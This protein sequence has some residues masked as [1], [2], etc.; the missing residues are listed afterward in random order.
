MV[1]T[2]ASRWVDK[3]IELFTK[4]PDQ[5]AQYFKDVPGSK[6]AAAQLPQVSGQSPQSNTMHS[7]S[8]DGLIRNATALN[9][10]G[11]HTAFSTYP[12]NFGIILNG[13]QDG[14]GGIHSAAGPAGADQQTHYKTSVHCSQLGLF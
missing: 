5:L 2:T 12:E 4:Y 1:A 13:L 6:H 14:Q 11:F 10:S 7:G 8:R 3:A 9:E